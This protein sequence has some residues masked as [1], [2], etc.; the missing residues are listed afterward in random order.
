MNKLTIVI[1]AKNEAESLPNVLKNLV[2]LNTKIIVSLPPNDEK[3]IDSIKKFNIKIHKQTYEGYGNSLVEAINIC[4]T[5]YFCIFNADGSFEKNDLKKMYDLIFNYEFI[6]TSRYLKNGSSD[7]DTII[8]YV[9]NR[10]FSFL[11]Q[12]LFSLEINDI[13][14]TYLMGKTKSF[15]NLNIKSSDFRFCVE[16]PI[17]M[18]LAG[19]K[20][21]SI[22]SYEKRRI[23]GKKKVN[24]FKDGLLILSEI[25]KLFFR[26]KLLRQK[27][28]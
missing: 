27:I 13:L 4:D 3:T 22:P 1:P 9:G 16:L 25:L 2:D 17:K 14:Y 12:F 24:A 26:Y 10:I 23:A 21:T 28:I 19:M 7:D 6:Y 11:G 5:E 18:Q 20:Y 15:N 8:T